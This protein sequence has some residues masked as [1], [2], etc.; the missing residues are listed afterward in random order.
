MASLVLTGDTSGQ[1]TVS[2]PAVAGTNTATLP[3]ATGEL[4]MLGTSGQTWQAVTGSRAL[5]TTYTN[6]TGKPILVHI[7]FNQNSTQQNTTFVIS[8]VTVTG[9]LGVQNIS[10]NWGFSFIIPPGGTYSATGNNTISV[11]SELR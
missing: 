5:A 8:G 11:W 6:S 2:A 3:L 4:S 7:D 9:L 1:V 10:S